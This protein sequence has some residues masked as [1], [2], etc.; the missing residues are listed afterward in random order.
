M[1]ANVWEPAGIGKMTSRLVQILENPSRPINIVGYVRNPATAPLSEF[2][3]KND[4]SAAEV[5]IFNEGI[6][7]VPCPHLISS[8]Q[9]GEQ[10]PTAFSARRL[11][12]A[13]FDHATTDVSGNEEALESTLMDENAEFFSA[14]AK[15]EGN[16]FKQKQGRHAR[17][18]STTSSRVRTISARDLV[19]IDTLQGGY[20]VV[21]IVPG[22][23]KFIFLCRV[24]R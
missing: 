6:A 3:K 11:A 7:Q 19:Q 4:N 1:S 13:N 8:D 14:A 18:P 21:K 22:L 9:A 23:R 12:V 20:G 17:Q 2:L 16:T 15:D 5:Y 24:T 10:T